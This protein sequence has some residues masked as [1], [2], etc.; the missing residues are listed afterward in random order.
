MTF[1]KAV[2]SRPV[3][4]HHS[5]LLLCADVWKLALQVNVHDCASLPRPPVFFRKDAYL[6]KP[7]LDPNTKARMKGG[8]SLTH[9]C[10]QS[11]RY[12]DQLWD[13]A[14]GNLEQTGRTVTAVP[15]AFR[16]GTSDIL[17]DRLR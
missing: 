9:P 10:P 14:A 7:K 6:S 16:D 11:S 3:Q 13:K 12:G 5:V 1:G 8:M 15:E 2:S 4:V 17:S